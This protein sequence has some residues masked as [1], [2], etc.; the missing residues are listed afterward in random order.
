MSFPLPGI[1][2][3]G[4]I[5]ADV[6]FDGLESANPQ[7]PQQHVL[8]LQSKLAA[9]G[10]TALK[11]ISQQF[12]RNKVALERRRHADRNDRNYLRVQ[13]GDLVLEL[14]LTFSS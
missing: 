8:N 1:C 14:E 3:L 2:G 11:L 9:M 7:L 10:A 4:C 5:L 12:Q 13:V 6:D